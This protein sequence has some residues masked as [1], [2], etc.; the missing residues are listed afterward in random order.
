MTAT[1]YADFAPEHVDTTRMAQTDTILSPRFY[2]TDFVAMD[3]IDVTPVRAEWD[4]LI[5]EMASDPNR[6]HFRRSEAFETA[7]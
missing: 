2:T 6:N 7:L 1:T 4:A 5:A 3:R